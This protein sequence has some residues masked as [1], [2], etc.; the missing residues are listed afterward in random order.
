MKDQEK[1]QAIADSIE[2]D[3]SELTMDTKLKDLENWDSIAVLSVIAFINENFQK[4]PKAEEILKY[5][6]VGE[7]MK[8]FQ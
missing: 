4:Y 3:V 1:M 7:L 2:M 8:V 5:E 6:T